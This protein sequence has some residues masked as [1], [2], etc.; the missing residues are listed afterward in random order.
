M[1][2]K[3]Y[4]H[5]FARPA[6]K[7]QFIAVHSH[8]YSITLLCQA[9]EVSERGY[10]AWKTREVSQ[11]CRKDARLSAEIQQIFLEHRQVYGSPRIHAVLK[12]RGNHCSRKRV[13]RLMQQLGLSAQSK[14]SHKPTTK[15]DPRSLVAPNHLN[16]RFSAE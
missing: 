15:S 6:V 10:Y 16:R 12:A 3:R 4:R 1:L 7:F 5:L 11:H 14:R 8:Q 9:L 2:K 13:M